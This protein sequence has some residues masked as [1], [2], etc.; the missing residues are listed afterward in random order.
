MNWIEYHT[1]T[2]YS[3]ILSFLGAEDVVYTCAQNNCKAVAITDR[4]TVQGY[5]IA[6]REAKKRGISLIYG[7]TVDCLDR[8]DRY[9]VTLLA[10]NRTG[11]ENIFALLR[12]MDDMDLSQ[13]RYVTRQ[14]LEARRDGLLLGA[15]ARD[16]Q[17]VRAIQL[18]RGDIALKNVALT[19]DYIELP[20]E[21]YD[22]SARLCLLSHESGVPTCAVQCATFAGA[23]NAYYHAHRAITQYWG[24]SE[25][26]P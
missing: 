10:K 5:L 25:T 9:A 16:G 19:Y 4:N 3:D 12:L 17:L 8:E 20:L 18:R 24:K 26:P 22:V 23:E 1:D 21:P 14:Q 6:E 2:R 11:R 15:S 7:M 13:G